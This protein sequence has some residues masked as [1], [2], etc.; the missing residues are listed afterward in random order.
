M[1]RARRGLAWQVRTKGYWGVAHHRGCH[2]C[3][4]QRSRVPKGNRA[5]LRPRLQGI[6]ML[7]VL[8]GKAQHH[9]AG[10]ADM[11]KLLRVPTGAARQMSAPKESAVR[12][13]HWAGKPR[14]HHPRVVADMVEFWCPH[15]SCA[16]MSAP[17]RKAL[18]VLRSWG[19]SP[20]HHPAGGGAFLSILV[21][22]MAPIS[23]VLATCVT[24]A[25]LQVDQWRVAFAADPN[26][27]DAPCAPG[28]CTLM[29]LTRRGWR[30][31]LIAD[32][33]HRERVGRRHQCGNGGGELPLS[34]G[35][36]IA[37]SSRA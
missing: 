30:P 24:A 32:R 5:G 29:L 28:G 13:A 21:T 4:V 18:F 2:R 19:Q 37:K 3:W 17:Q 35:S 1:S 22:T 26:G 33:R 25:G 10:V 15:R 8:R 31:A 27:A 12:R 7:I 34:S 14:V 20:N 11:V 16:P 23:A 9:P 36:V 6:Q